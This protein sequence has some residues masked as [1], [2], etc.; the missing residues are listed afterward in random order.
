MAHSSADYDY[1]ADDHEPS[2]DHLNDQ[3]LNREVDEL[4]QYPNLWVL[5]LP[6]NFTRRDLETIFEAFGVVHIESLNLTGQGSRGEYNTGYVTM[7]TV[8]QAR[9]AYKHLKNKVLEKDGD[10]YILQIR[11]ARRSPPR[12]PPTVGRHNFEPT[13]RRRYRGGIYS[14]NPYI[15]RF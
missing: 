3:C 6:L 1:F 4:I 15:R 11:Q 2:K 5:G 14:R 7:E 12:S 13:Y 8:E 9:T 10:Q